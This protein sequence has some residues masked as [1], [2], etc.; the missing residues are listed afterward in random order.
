[1]DIPNWNWLLFGGVL[2]AFLAID[3]YAHRGERHDSKRTAIVWSVIWIVVGLGFGGI[4]W[5][6]FGGRP[7]ADYL[8]AYLI[9]KSLSMD[10]LFVFLIIFKMLGIPRDNQ[11]T[12]LS[13]GIFGALVLRGIFVFA[14]AAAIERYHWVVYVFGGL[15]LFAA[16]RTFVEDP[17]EQKENRLVRWL[18]N[19]LPVTH[20]V[21]GD[22]FVVREHGRRV[23]TPLLIAVLALEATDVLFAIDSVPAAFA[24]SHEPFIVYSSN[25]FAI[26]GL[27]AL[28]I[29]LATTLPQ[30]TYLH[31]GLSLVLAFAAVKLMIS[32]WVEIPVW[33]SILFIV[34]TL[35]VS[36]W[37]S[38][39]HERRRQVSQETLPG[40]LD[41]P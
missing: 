11:R 18:S 20:R 39:R 10:N 26:L 35:G 38:L 29:V 24:I 27:R 17:T 36:I 16:W 31:Y 6:E 3:L 19:H 13:W 1:M 34:V 21:H 15:L 32:E 41:G 37:A 8:G 25:A 40:T 2:F 4:V 14:G 9:E 7:A 28:Y 23:A 22:H 12:A 30:M 5:W 33:L